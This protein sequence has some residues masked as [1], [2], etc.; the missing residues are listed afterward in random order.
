M[1]VKLNTKAYEHAKAL[2]REGTFVADSRDDWSE[3]APTTQQLSDFLDKQGKREYGRW[4]L[5][6]DDEA[7]DESKEHYKFPF[8]DLARVHRCAVISGESRAGQYDHDE[9]RDALK[10]LLTRIDDQ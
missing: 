7:S 1:T 9:I 2:I 6:V 3:H 8:G 5:G 10:D 4:F